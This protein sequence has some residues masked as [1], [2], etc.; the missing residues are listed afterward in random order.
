MALQQYN[1]QIFDVLDE[2]PVADESPEFFVSR[3]Q[4]EP[5]THLQTTGKHVHNSSLITAC[6]IHIQVC[7]GLCHNETIDN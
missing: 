1:V 6:I 7:T 3:E 2:L 4:V 5:S